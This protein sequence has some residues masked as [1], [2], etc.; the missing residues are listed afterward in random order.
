MVVQQPAVWQRDRNSRI[1]RM[2]YWR[3]KLKRNREITEEELFIGPRVTLNF[4]LLNTLKISSLIFKFI[5]YFNFLIL[6][7]MHSMCWVHPTSRAHYFQEKLFKIINSH[8]V[9]PTDS[10][11]IFILTLCPSTWHLTCVWVY[12]QY[13]GS[14]YIHTYTMTCT[15]AFWWRHIL[16]L[17]TY[18][19]VTIY[20][21]LRA[22]IFLSPITSSKSYFSKLR[23]CFGFISTRTSIN[24]IKS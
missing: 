14:M 6:W 1:T 3:Y 13:Q 11:I 19:Q 16:V 23:H 5:S 20:W 18:R 8:K 22:H 7:L 21:V 24:P 4:N 9:P 2:D 17:L 15:Y 12:F 10:A